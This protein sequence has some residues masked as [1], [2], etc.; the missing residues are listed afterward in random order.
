LCRAVLGAL[1]ATGFDAGERAAYLAYHRG[2]LLRFLFWQQDKEDEAVATFDQQARRMGAAMEQLRRDAA[3]EGVAE[4]GEYESAVASL[5]AYVSTFRGVEGYDVDPF[6][7]DPVFPAV[8]KALH[9]LA[10]QLGVDMRNEAFVHHLLLRAHE[11]EAAAV[12]AGV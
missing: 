1:R 4:A 10:N 11:P 6:S 12:G 9:G 2:W 5:A 3:E 7:A 8:F